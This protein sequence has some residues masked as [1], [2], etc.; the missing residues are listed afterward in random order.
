MLKTRNAEQVFRNWIA[1]VSENSKSSYERIIP[2]FFQMVSQVELIEIT[3]DTLE[4]ITPDDVYNRYIKELKD[5]GFKDSTISNYISVVRSFIT[6]L[7]ENR[8]FSDID[9]DYLRKTALSTKRLSNDIENR[10]KM[11]GDDYEAFSEW[12]L[13]KG[14]SKRYAD[15]GLK[16]AMALKFMYVTAIRIDATFSNI[17]WK[18][19]RKEIDD[20][21]NETYV[22]YALD[23][24]NKVNKK[25]IS[26]EFYEELNITM[27]NTN[28]EGL[29][30]G[31][32]SKQSFTRLMKEFS[33]ETGREITPHS[34][35]VGAGTKLYK[36]TKDIF[37]VQRFLDHSDPKVTM[38]YIR[39]DDVTES[40]SFLMSSK[41]TIDD[42]DKLSYD[43]LAMI[44]KKRPELAVTIINDARKEGLI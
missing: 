5:M 15:K 16:Y 27:D 43:D 7:E 31:D 12:L 40:G 41:I 6:S 28:D 14:W 2:Q 23:K 22:I 1:Q 32:L 8:L 9:F 36:I 35:K 44:I 24:G 25:P 34:I 11:S 39:V 10:K 30:F 21:G 29:V 19:I 38:R 17:R 42:L 20:Y 26:M 13:E 3:E 4:S 18:N 37:K 33:D